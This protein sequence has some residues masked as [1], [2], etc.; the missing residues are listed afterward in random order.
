[1]SVVTNFVTTLVT[2]T[3][4]SLPAPCITLSVMNEGDFVKSTI[5]PRMVLQQEL[6]R[7]IQKN[8]KY[9]LRAF[10]KSL[11]LSHALLSLVIS[12]KKDLSKKSA[13]KIA[14]ELGMHPS[15]L[16][17]KPSLPQVDSKNRA[18]EGRELL[19][20]QLDTFAIISD[21]HHYA[22]LSLLE[23]PKAKFEAKWIC[24]RLGISEMEAKLSMERLKRLNL[25]GQ[26]GGR[27][28]Q[29][30][31]PINIENNIATAATKKFNRQLLEK[32]VESME[33]QSKDRRSFS[34]MTFAM[35]PALVVEAEKHI[36]DYLRSL[37]DELEVKGSPKDVYCLTAQL[38]P[39]SQV[40]D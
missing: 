8:P 17:P 11:G 21:W 27:W 12:G 31:A 16:M 39:V 28:R 33:N 30:S 19:E 35:D 22:I 40:E 6:S 26:K 20:M 32:A 3:F 34:S 23:L 2:I 15:R 25:I 38:F 7:R 29:V 10:A 13:T 1:M 36:R 9:S 4:P 37:S 24:K 18:D 5:G 14:S